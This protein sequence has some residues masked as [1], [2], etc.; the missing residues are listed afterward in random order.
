MATFAPP[1]VV[2]STPQPGGR[3]TAAAVALGA[4]RGGSVTRAKATPM[5]KAAK[6]PAKLPKQSAPRAQKAPQPKA[7]RTVFNPVEGVMGAKEI[8]NIA[9]REAQE[10]LKDELEP[11]KGGQKETG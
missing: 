2:K 3:K 8:R 5:P 11:M 7:Q 10:G 1:A 9:P 6:A 4:P